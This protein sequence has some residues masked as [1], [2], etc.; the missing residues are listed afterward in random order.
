MGPRV[1]QDSVVRASLL[2]SKAAAGLQ[3]GP[4]DKDA[5]PLQRDSRDGSMHMSPAL[6]EAE[7]LLA[8]SD[9][10]TTKKVPPH[11]MGAV[12]NVNIR[13]RIVVGA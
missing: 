7:L 10:M 5:G 6:L 13:W 9:L 1:K 3:Q 8:R 4:V 2:E 11:W 12:F